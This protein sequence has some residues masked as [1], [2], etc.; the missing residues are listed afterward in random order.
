M[1]GN[2]GVMQGVR[3]GFFSMKSVQMQGLQGSQG[4]LA[5]MYFSSFCAYRRK[6]R[7]FTRWV[8]AA[9]PA[10]P[11]TPSTPDRHQIV[12]LAIT[13]LSEPCELDAAPVRQFERLAVEPLE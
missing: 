2:A 13:V 4:Y 1:Q 12:A 7:L 10:T 3:H 8:G 11:A 6:E 9:H 5:C